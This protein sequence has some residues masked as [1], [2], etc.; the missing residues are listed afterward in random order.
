MLRLEGDKS[1]FDIVEE[2]DL[3]YEDV[4]SYVN[5]FLEHDLIEKTKVLS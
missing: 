2:L 4:L 1:V 5:K 3:E